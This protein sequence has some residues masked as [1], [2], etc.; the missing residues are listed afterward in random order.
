MRRM[1][2]WVAV[3][4]DALVLWAGKA[5]RATEFLAPCVR[6]GRFILP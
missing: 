1:D 6:D 4:T 2:K 3:S 5:R